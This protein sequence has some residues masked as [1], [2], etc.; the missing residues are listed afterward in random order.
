MHA[1]ARE[2]IAKHVAGRTFGDVVEVGSRN[3]NGGVRDLI[4]CA[5]Y[6]GVD[7]VAGDGV[8]IVGDARAMTFDADLVVCCE[9][10][11]HERHWGALLWRMWTWVRPGGA[12]LVTAACE[13]RAPHGCGG[14]DVG[15]GE[16][17]GNVDPWIFWMAAVGDGVF[18]HDDVAG[19]VRLMARKVRDGD[20]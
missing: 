11:E 8:D 3:V 14:G 16:W 9:V 10:L 18:E 4:V 15:E 20:A 13:P 2:W 17:Y 6:V 1:S 12:L 19:D 5:S 7:L